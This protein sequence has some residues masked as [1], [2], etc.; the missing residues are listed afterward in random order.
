MVWTDVTWG[1]PAGDR[2][3]RGAEAVAGPGRI[4]RPQLNG[5]RAWMPTGPLVREP[6]PAFRDDQSPTRDQT[7][8]Y[9]TRLR[10]VVLE[11]RVSP[12]CTQARSTH[13]RRHVGKRRGSGDCARVVDRRWWAGTGGCGLTPVAMSV[14]ILVLT[15]R[16]ASRGRFGISDSFPT[17]IIAVPSCESADPR[18]LNVNGGPCQ[19]GCPEL[20]Q[21]NVR[22]M[23]TGH[24]HACRN[25]A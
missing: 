21:G 16:H 24:E 7:A 23:A 13:T 9:T 6:L 20:V 4:L 11:S 12:R 25:G 18:F 8:L 17:C 1:T 10:D 15:N 22:R 2:S 3:E 14:T 19:A 5:E